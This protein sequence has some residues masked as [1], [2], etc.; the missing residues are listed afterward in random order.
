MF[1][2]PDKRSAKGQF[3]KLMKDYNN[4]KQGALFQ[5]AN[6]SKVLGYKFT[7]SGVYFAPILKFS[8]NGDDKIG[9]FSKAFGELCF[10]FYVFDAHSQYPK[11][12]HLE[13]NSFQRNGNSHERIHAEESTSQSG[14]SGKIK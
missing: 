2:G 7:N 13:R 1:V 6:A 10:V 5:F 14:N 3:L 8:L 9:D 12:M 11:I 4:F